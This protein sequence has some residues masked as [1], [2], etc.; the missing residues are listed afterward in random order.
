MKIFLPV[1]G[2]YCSGN[3]NLGLVKTLVKK[4]FSGGREEFCQDRK[5]G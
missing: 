4:Q 2:D 1:T 5:M 3:F